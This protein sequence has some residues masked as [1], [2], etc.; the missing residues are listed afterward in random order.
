MLE[1]QVLAQYETNGKCLSHLRIQL[2]TGRHHQIRVQFSHAG[3]PLFGD[4]KYNPD[5]IPVSRLYLCACQLD[6]LHPSTGKLLHFEIQPFFYEEFD[7]S[8]PS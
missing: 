8:S 1:Y 3:C 6:F 2:Q 4:R 7:K 5:G